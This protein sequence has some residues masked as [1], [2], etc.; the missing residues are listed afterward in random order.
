MKALNTMVD[1]VP[2]D[3]CWPPFSLASSADV[4]R[5]PFMEL[6]DEGGL[7]DGSLHVVWVFDGRAWCGNRGDRIQGILKSFAW[8]WWKGLVTEWAELKPRNICDDRTPV[9]RNQQT[10]D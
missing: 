5:F 7:S 8:L 4:S 1:G 2:R 6:A 3:A 9:G 10:Y